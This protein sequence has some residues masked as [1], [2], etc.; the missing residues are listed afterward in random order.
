MEIQQ[1]DTRHGTANQSAFSHGNCLPYTGVPFG[2]NYFAP[3]TTDQHG[4]WW[5]HPDDRLFQGYRLTHQPSPWMGDF[6]QLVL[7][8]IS[9][10]LSEPSLFHA[11]SSY[12]PEECTFCP[13]HLSI[14]QLRYDIRSTLIPSMYGGIL[15]IAYQGNESGLL[16]SF[17]GKFRLT[18]KDAHTVVGEITHFSGAED[19]NFT[20]YFVLRLEQPLT[21]TELTV[22]SEEASSVLLSFGRISEQTI[23]FGTSFIS[24]EQAFCNLDREKNQTADDYLEHSRYQWQTYFD[25]IKVTHHES[26]V[27]R[28]FY[29]N[30]YRVF[31]FPQTFYEIDPTGEKIHYDTTSRTVR[32]GVLYTNNGFWD[33]YKTVYPLFSLIAVEKYEEMLEGFLNSYRESG[34]LPKWLSP[35]ERGLMPGTLIDAVIADAAVKEIRKDLMPEFLEGMKK[36]AEIQ[37]DRP[38]YGRQG[39]NDY[40]TYGYVPNHYH[41]SVN[42]TLDYSYSD[43]CIS[44][45]AQKL[46]DEKT[47][48]DYR[49]QSFNYRHIFDPDTGFMRS[50]NTEGQFRE[51][52]SPI[53]WGQDHA[54]GSAWQSSFAVYHDFAGLIAAYGK[55]RFEEQLIQLCN[56]PP[57]FDVGGYGFEIHEMSEMAALEFGQ[58]AISN[59]PSFHYPY[60]FSYIGK[61]E[62]AQPLIK[63][64]MTQTFNDSPTGYPGDEDNGSMAAWYIFNSLG[65]YPV[66]PGTGEYVIGLPLIDHAVLSLSN[67]NKLTIDAS[68]NKPQQQFI[69]EIKRNGLEHTKLFF[70]HQDLSEGGTISYQLGIVPN[71]RKYREEDLPFSL[72]SAEQ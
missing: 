20:F 29:H 31:L 40:L 18:V 25:R 6:S 16:L 11:Q 19:P 26:Q 14:H 69:H 21:D 24:T 72:S 58:L 7:T 50:K 27:L 51:P 39:T 12:R 56:Q 68:P 62:M 61:P 28:T 35:D 59:Q 47:A 23:R 30:L 53:R 43:F 15:S 3:Q 45:V 63:Q 33:T 60:L 54:E 55:Q 37:S 44:Q 49:R 9:G 32:P 46:A 34:F 38:N 66:T 22:S 71:P 36:A 8:P 42:H 5:F 1:I 17:P 64:L 52:F 2:M 4:S 41:E 65:F 48:D 57:K 10:E 70:T 13:T 67:G